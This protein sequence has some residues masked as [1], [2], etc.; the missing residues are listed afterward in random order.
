[1]LLL[2]LPLLL[3]LLSTLLTGMPFSRC[4]P[5]PPPALP[6]R[7][8]PTDQAN[9]EAAGRGGVIEAVVSVLKDHADQPMVVAEACGALRNFA[10]NNVANREAC[11]R[12]GAVEAVR[13]AL[14]RHGKM[15]TTTT[16]TTMT[17]WTAQ[18]HTDT[19]A[20]ASPS[21]LFVCFCMSGL[22]NATYY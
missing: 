7:D 8:R 15:T 18:T 16:T 17:T 20:R 2:L 6:T 12:L 1:M 19:R 11:G 21:A 4:R 5:R 10:A 13:A 22:N 9:T 3:P 14:L